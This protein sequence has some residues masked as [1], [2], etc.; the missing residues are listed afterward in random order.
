MFKNWK[1]WI[2]FK[3][4]FDL[5]HSLFNN[6]N[7]FSYRKLMAG[8]S[9]FMTAYKLSMSVT[10]N[11]LKVKLVIVWLIFGAICIGLVT[12]PDLIK[13]LSANKQL[14]PDKP[15]IKQQ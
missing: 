11:E 5:Y 1:Q 15:Q 2:I 14:D 13:F 8:F 9:V 12:I 6:D 4:V 7:G 10:D 3:P